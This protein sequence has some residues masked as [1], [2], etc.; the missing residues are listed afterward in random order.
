VVTITGSGQ[1]DRDEYIPYAGG[2]RLFRQVA[3]TLGRRGIAVLRLDDRGLG[4]SGGSAVGSTSADFADDIRAAIAYLRARQDIDPDRIGIVGHSEGGAIAPMI[5]ATDPRLKAMVVMAA[6]GEPG[7]EISMAQNKYIVD[8]DT[9][10][11]P[12][13]RD[14]VLRAARASLDPAKQ[15]IPWVK[16]WMS[17]DPAPAARQVKAATLILQGATDRQVPA[18]QAEKLAALIRA[19]GNSDVTV[20]VFPSTNHLFIE[21]PSGDFNGYDKLRTNKVGTGVLGALADWLAMRLSAKTELRGAP[22]DD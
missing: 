2:I 4:A 14:S 10:L 11:T 8:R 15:T 6:P 5:A 9:T 18:D 20:R 22:R 1:Q 17:Y 21:D 12:A 19:G 13:Q 16:F 7:I 3:D